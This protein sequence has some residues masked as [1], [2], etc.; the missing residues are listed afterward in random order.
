MSLEETELLLDAKKFFVAGESI[1]GGGMKGIALPSP[2]LPPPNNI[3]ALPSTNDID[4]LEPM[5]LF[6]VCELIALTV[7][8]FFGGGPGRSSITQE[9]E[10]RE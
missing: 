6:R 4:R 8:D 2:T 9:D 7:L 1:G 10:G 5:L 3:A